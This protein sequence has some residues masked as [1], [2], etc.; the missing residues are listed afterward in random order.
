ML[1]CS[2]FQGSHTA[3]AIAEHFENTT[4][5]FNISNKISHIIIDIATNIIREFSLPGFEKVSVHDSPDSSDFESDDEA[6]VSMPTSVE[7]LFDYVN[8]HVA[9]FSHTSSKQL[10][11]LRYSQRPQQL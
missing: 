11:S 8:K 2:C 9:C 6:D 1:A 10:P 4:A 7:G 5:I 3:E